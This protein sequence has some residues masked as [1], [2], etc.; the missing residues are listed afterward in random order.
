[1]L[2]NAIYLQLIL[3]AVVILWFAFSKRR[4]YVESLIKVGSVSALFLGLW[5]GGVWV[6]PPLYV[7]VIIVSVFIVLILVHVRKPI[8][9]SSRWRVIL[10]NSPLCIIVPLSLVLLWQGSIGRLKPIGQF[11]ELSSPFKPEQGACVLSGGTSPLLNLHIFPS[12]LARDI[13]QRYALDIIKM[14]PNGFR[15]TKGYTLN[16]K[17]DNINAYSMFE[18]A[19]YSP[20]SGKV[21]EQENDLPDQP[22]GSSDKVKT[23]GNGVVLQ[24]SQYHVHLHHLKQGSVLVGLGD[25]VKVGQQLGR[26]GNSGNTIEP[27]LHLHAETIVEEG[28]PRIYGQPVHM[29]FNRRYMARGDCF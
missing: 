22:I 9:R 14:E 15:V 10:S 28:N 8:T 11:I 19:V 26:I 6:Y 17:P 2:I 29:K 25:H 13:G 1:M 3:I 20:C 27:H 12:E 24:C 23:W 16:P 7:L 21:V 5:L 4:S 18:A